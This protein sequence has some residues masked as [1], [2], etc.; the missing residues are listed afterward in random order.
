[1]ALHE[2]A[3]RND[4]LAEQY[5]AATMLGGYKIPTAMTLPLA[6]LKRALR[7]ASETFADAVQMHQDQHT[8]GKW[9]EEGPEG[10]K[11]RKFVPDP[12]YQTEDDGSPK[13][14]LDAKGN[15]TS[16]RLIAQG[17]VQLKN[18]VEHQREKREMDRATTTIRVPHLSWPQ[19]EGKVASIEGNITDAL[20]DYFDDMPKPGEEKKA[21]AP[22]GKKAGAAAT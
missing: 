9:V 12:V 8:E 1:M 14:K 18:A 13:F 6:Q 3:V 19:L 21:E 22:K 10:Q 5:A 20:W 4:R 15:P 7:E 17:R 16:E 11:K 2:H